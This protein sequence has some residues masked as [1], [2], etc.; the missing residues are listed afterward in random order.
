MTNNTSALIKVAARALRPIRPTRPTRPLGTTT[1]LVRRPN[2]GSET[3][4]A[5]PRQQYLPGFDPKHSMRGPYPS[6]QTPD[7]GAHYEAQ[8]RDNGFVRDMQG[9]WVHRNSY[10]PTTPAG[11]HTSQSVTTADMPT[12]PLPPAGITAGR[13][14]AFDDAP[15]RPLP[16]AG[17]PAERLNVYEG[18]PPISVRPIALDVPPAA[19]RPGSVPN[20]NPAQSLL[21]HL[22]SARKAAT[23]S[24]NANRVISTVGGGVVGA[25]LSA[26]LGTW[27]GHGYQNGAG[28]GQN[29]P[30]MQP[31]PVTTMPQPTYP[32][33]PYVTGPTPRSITLPQM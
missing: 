17:I 31:Q 18:M 20:A 24:L 22:D 26:G 13:S 29:Q 3:P 16:P 32:T 5:T 11:T 4:A 6:K 2:G 14:A 21:G 15:T 19:F 10:D 25:G 27:L 8:M 9:N 30:V 33:Y 28:N 23:R 1:P 7:A 12:R